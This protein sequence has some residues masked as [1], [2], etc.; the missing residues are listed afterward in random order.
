MKKLALLLAS[1]LF[2]SATVPPAVHVNQIGYLPDA[3]KRAVVASASKTPLAW[4]LID[5]RGR[6]IA[7]GVTRVTGDDPVSGDHVHLVDLS[8]ARAP[9]E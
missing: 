6:S 2:V 1:T 7:E 5:A 8:Q 4:R 3:A 9:G